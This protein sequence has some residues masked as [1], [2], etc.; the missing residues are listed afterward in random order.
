MNPTEG[1]PTLG[2]KSGCKRLARAGSE[3]ASEIFPMLLNQKCA[4][5]YSTPDLGV[6]F[7]D[8]NTVNSVTASQRK[9]GRLAEKQSPA[10]EESN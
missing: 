7:S 9:T 5:Y 4:A 1:P 8:P 2:D 10:R 3:A 6:W